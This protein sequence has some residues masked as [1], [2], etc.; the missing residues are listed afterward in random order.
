MTDVVTAVLMQTGGGL[1]KW[2]LIGL[3]FFFCDFENVLGIWNGLETP[4][5]NTNVRNMRNKSSG[6]LNSHRPLKRSLV[7]HVKE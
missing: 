3:G 6:I 4:V 5:L 1:S 2:D 7:F